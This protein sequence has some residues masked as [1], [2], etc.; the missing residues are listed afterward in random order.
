MLRTLVVDDEASI[1]Q[2][3]RGLLQSAGHQVVAV[4][5]GQEALAA[6]SAGA[7][8]DLMVIDI[9]LGDM[10]GFDVITAARRR[11]PTLR[12]LVIS[13]YIGLDSVELRRKLRREAVNHALSKPFEAR[14]L[15][16][17]VREMFIDELPRA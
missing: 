1:R 16:R 12:I 17:T 11:A 14:E 2:L 15:L 9:S 5:S 7:P 4:S 6:L 3:V 8:P 13:G 10:S